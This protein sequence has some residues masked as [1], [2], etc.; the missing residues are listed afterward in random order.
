MKLITGEVTLY[1]I[2]IRKKKI[3]S[4]WRA[5]TRIQFTYK[6][7]KGAVIFCGLSEIIYFRK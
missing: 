4:I 3:P 2:V 7:C 6:K 5:R 1:D